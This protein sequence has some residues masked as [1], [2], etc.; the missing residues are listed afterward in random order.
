[1]LLVLFANLFLVKAQVEVFNSTYD[2]TNNVSTKYADFVKIKKADKGSD[3]LFL[4]GNGKKVTINSFNM[5]GFKYKGMLFKFDNN[6]PT[7]Y[8][9]V[10]VISVGKIVYYENGTARMQMLKNGSNRG[11]YV[12]YD[13]G[14]EFYYG[15]ALNGGMYHENEIAR[16]LL[17]GNPQYK[18]LCDCLM[19][20]M[21]YPK[22][23]QKTENLKYEYK[24]W[25]ISSRSLEKNRDCVK[26]FN[27]E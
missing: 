17:I 5:W 6:G 15:E 1:M 25:Y 11:S 18:E 4:D 24:V 3:A 10:A 13:E 19:D 16:S 2:Y 7:H 12:K 20:G 22:R 26:A 14:Y 8:P 23:Y 21:K 9:L 27:G